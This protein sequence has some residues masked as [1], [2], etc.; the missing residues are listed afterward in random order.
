MGQPLFFD[1][2]S[3]KASGSFCSALWS[4]KYFSFLLLPFGFWLSTELTIWLTLVWSLNAS[5]TCLGEW[6]HLQLVLIAVPNSLP[7]NSAGK[8]R[9]AQIAYHVHLPTILSSVP[10]PQANRGAPG[11]IFFLSWRNGWLLDS[12]KT[13]PL[14]NSAHCEYVLFN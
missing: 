1:R 11:A 3:R 7:F 9:I 12:I 13:L 10:G 2:G 8:Y 5:W 4:E 14:P 6:N